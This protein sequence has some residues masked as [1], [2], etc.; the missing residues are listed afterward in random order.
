M[1]RVVGYLALPIGEEIAGGLKSAGVYRP[2]KLEDQEH[3]APQ[4]AIVMNIRIGDS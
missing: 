1:L 3:V 2:I 4:H